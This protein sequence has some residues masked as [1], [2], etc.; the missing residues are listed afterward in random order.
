MK[1]S[2][3]LM[4][5]E[6]IENTMT[7]KLDRDADYELYVEC[8]MLAGTQ[9]L[10]LILH[11]MGVTETTWDLLHTH[12]PVLPAEVPTELKPL[13]EGLKFIE[14]IRP[15]YLRG[16]NPWNPEDG[17]TCLRNYQAIKAYALK[18]LGAKAYDLG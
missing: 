14:D 16:T 4:R 11:E 2:D 17:E 18:L 13:F 3:H 12:K 7:L 1:T 5:I 8:C 15:G 9:A 6:H 10:N